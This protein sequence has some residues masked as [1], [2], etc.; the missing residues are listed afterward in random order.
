[1]KMRLIAAI[2]SG[3]SIVALAIVWLGAAW[4]V[5]GGNTALADPLNNAGCIIGQNCGQA[6]DCNY[7]ASRCFCDI[8]SGYTVGKCAYLPR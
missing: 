3:R 8:P 4:I 6:S 5:W 7:P 1:M 2:L